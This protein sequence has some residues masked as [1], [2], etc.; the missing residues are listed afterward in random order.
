MSRFRTCT[1]APATSNHSPHQ[2]DLLTASAAGAGGGLGGKH[3]L[4]ALGG[5][6]GSGRLISVRP[7]QAHEH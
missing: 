3:T 4:S 7:P 6:G 2:W 5:G 1:L